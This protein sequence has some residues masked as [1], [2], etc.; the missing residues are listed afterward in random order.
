MPPIV[1]INNKDIKEEIDYEE[2]LPNLSDQ[3]EIKEF[4]PECDFYQEES[5]IDD[6][7]VIVVKHERE[8]QDHDQDS[9][10]EDPLCGC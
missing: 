7:N 2:N 1:S 10:Q 5:I 3:I 4:K 8:Q 9:N 6:L